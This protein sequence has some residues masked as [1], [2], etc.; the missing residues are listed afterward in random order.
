MDQNHNN[1]ITKEK[2]KNSM[3]QNYINLLQSSINNLSSLGTDA[4]IPQYFEAVGLELAIAGLGLLYIVRIIVLLIVLLIVPCCIVI[5]LKNVKPI[6][7]AT[8][9]SKG[10]KEFN[11]FCD[12][13]QVLIT[14]QNNLKESEIKKKKLINKKIDE[15]FSFANIDKKYRTE[16]LKDI[17]GYKEGI[18]YTHMTK[19]RYGKYYDNIKPVWPCGQLDLVEDLDEVFQW[20]LRIILLTLYLCLFIPIFA[21]LW[22]LSKAILFAILLFALIVFLCINCS[23]NYII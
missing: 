3:L 21:V 5:L 14:E 6:Q 2:E 23:E 4:T 22:G 1:N 16:A 20:I 8:M 18:F 11:D 10:Y 15:L 9:R 19:G 13:L 17:K 12:K 7:W